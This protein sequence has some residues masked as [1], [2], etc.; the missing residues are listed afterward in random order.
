M[1]LRLFLDHCVPTSVATALANANHD[2]LRLKDFLPT[3]SPDPSLARRASVMK[4]R[5]A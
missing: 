1:G 3:N 4:L 5:P 2:V